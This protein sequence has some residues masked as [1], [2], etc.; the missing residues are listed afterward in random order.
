MASNREI[1]LQALLATI[2]AAV[3]SGT[4]VRRNDGGASYSAATAVYLDIMDGDPGEPDIGL[5]PERYFWRHEAE[6]YIGIE[7]NT[8]PVRASERDT[9][10]MAIDAAINADPTLGNKVQDSEV[11][12]PRVADLARAEGGPGIAATVLPVILEYES[13]TRA[14]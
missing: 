10:I 6:I 2:R 14:G 7:G 4:I 11:G 9:L 1:A 5:S 13:A 8:G 3:P 12:T